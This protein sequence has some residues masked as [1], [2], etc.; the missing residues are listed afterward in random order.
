[1]GQYGS[2]YVVLVHHV[3]H[4]IGLLIHHVVLQLLLVHLLLI[5]LLLL[6]RRQTHHVQLR[7]LGLGMLHTVVQLRVGRSQQSRSRRRTTNC[8][9]LIIILVL[10]WLVHPLNQLGGQ[11]N[12]N[13][14][15]QIN[16]LNQGV[17]QPNQNQNNNQTGTVGGPSSASTLLTAAN[18]Q[19]DNRV[20]HAQ[21]QLAQL[22]MV[23]LAA[24]QQQKI[25]QQKM[26]QQQLQHYMVN[27]KTN[28]MNNMMHQ[29]HIQ[30][31]ILPHPRQ[32][33]VPNL[34]STLTHNVVC[35][36]FVLELPFHYPSMVSRI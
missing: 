5:D 20:Q 19:L 10:V 25:N 1:M 6:L 3:V 27:Q 28:H 8:S 7:Q 22:N 34:H 29:H 18:P 23:R 24:Q 2:L 33:Q 14:P 16:Q 11:N 26:N 31:S 36:R 12:I 13:T 9:S 32:F 30:G 4:M 17:N 21:A 15:R 35:E